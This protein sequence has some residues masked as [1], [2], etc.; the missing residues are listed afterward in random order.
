MAG[1]RAI[2]VALMLTGCTPMIAVSLTATAEVLCA[3][4]D[5]PAGACERGKVLRWI[6]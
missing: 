1:L 3:V 4:P 6:K 2:L 5:E